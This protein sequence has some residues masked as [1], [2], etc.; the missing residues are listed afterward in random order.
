MLKRLTL[1]QELSELENVISAYLHSLEEVPSSSISRFA[2]LNNLAIQLRKKFAK[3]GEFHDLDL[4]IKTYQEALAIMPQ[5]DKNR[6]IVLNNLANSLRESYQAFGNK[7]DLNQAII[8]FDEALALTPPLSLERIAL[9]TNCG[10]CLRER[11]SL[12]GKES[13]LDKAISFYKE[14]AE[15]TKPNIRDRVSIKNSL[16]DIYLDQ[17][18]QNLT[19]TKEIAH[20]SNLDIDYIT[21]INEELTSE[22]LE[23][24]IVPLINAISEIQHIINMINGKARDYVLIKSIT[25]NSPISIGLEGVNDTVKLIQET[26]VPWRRKHAETMAQLLEQEK[27]AEIESKRADIL[28]KRARAAR[29]RHEAEKASID[30]HRQR[31]E[32]NRMSLEN[33]KLKIELYR[34]KV[35]LALG[36]LERISSNLPEADKLIYL[37]RL[38]PSLDF[39]IN[40]DIDVTIDK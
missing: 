35:E 25:Q 31:E 32:A 13:D 38:L 23:S 15:L 34:S 4:A 22:F 20:Y 19:K 21:F 16:S 9:L 36:V 12:T 29:E 28:E 18:A 1:Q 14:A 11:F 24:Q 27:L 6:P 17:I 2:I 7:K 10:H 30:V 40:S 39:L 8:F 37:S 5:N 26:V 3:T 33:E